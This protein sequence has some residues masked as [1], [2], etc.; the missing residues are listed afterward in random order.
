MIKFLFNAAFV[1]TACSALRRTT[2]INVG[3]IV[4]TRMPNEVLKG[5]SAAYFKVG[6]IIVDGSVNQWNKMTKPGPGEPGY[7]DPNKKE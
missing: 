2:S 6:D 3:K 7:V 5:T 1:S 4:T